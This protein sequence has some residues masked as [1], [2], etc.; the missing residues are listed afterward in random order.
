VPAESEDVLE[1]LKHALVHGTHR[2]ITPL[3]LL[4]LSIL[5]QLLRNDARGFG[6]G[7][8]T[9]ILYNRIEP[10]RSPNECH[11]R[12]IAEVL[13]VMER[14]DLV[15]LDHSGTVIRAAAL[16]G[17]GKDTLRTLLE[18]KRDDHPAFLEAVARL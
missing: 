6:H 8:A 9:R 5:E 13:E 3:Q 15:S 7:S 18:L 4:R 16:T 2:H 1:Q 12:T 11:L 14:A 17:K 10:D